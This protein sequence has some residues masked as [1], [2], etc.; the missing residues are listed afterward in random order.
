MFEIEKYLKFAKKRGERVLENSLDKEHVKVFLY[1]YP[2]LDRL[3]KE[4]EG[5]IYEKAVRSYGGRI[6]AEAVAEY[7]AN[8]ILYMRAL[9]FLKLSLDE[10]L[11][12][13]SD[14]EKKLVA[15]RYFGWKKSRI[16]ET[17]FEGKDR[18]K[19]ERSYFRRQEKLLKKI[20]VLMQTAG[21]DRRAFEETYACIEELQCVFRFVASGRDKKIFEKEKSW[22]S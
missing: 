8:Q 5:H 10:V 1:S 12:K 20:A 21:L 22:F 15:A 6:N 9:E 16:K 4:Y 14:T 3:V 11:K 13:L 2:R 18:I 7:I 19:S 17:L